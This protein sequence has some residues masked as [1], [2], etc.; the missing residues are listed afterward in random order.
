[1]QNYYF[2][3]IRPKLFGAKCTCLHAHSH[4]R[5]HTRH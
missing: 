1:M 5:T 3:F 4:T 2:I